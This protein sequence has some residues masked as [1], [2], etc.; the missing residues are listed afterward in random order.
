MGR[1]MGDILLWP[2]PVANSRRSPYT[3]RNANMSRASEKENAISHSAWQN[4]VQ[5]AGTPA[6][7]ANRLRRTRIALN[8]NQGDMAKLAGVTEGNWSL[9]ETGR[10]R[11]SL[12]AALRLVSEA[13]IS[14]DWI[15]C[16]V[17]DR[18]PHWL[19]EKLRHV[20]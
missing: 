12:N 3:L 19:A 18:L 5:M 16:G 7:I 8:L 11:I 6:S 1:F 17:V 10:R 9:F 13:Q 20:A 14:L 4:F 15:Y 2:Q